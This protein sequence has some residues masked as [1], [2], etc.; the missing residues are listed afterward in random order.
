MAVPLVLLAGLSI[1]LGLYPS[2]LMNLLHAVIEFLG[3]EAL[4]NRANIHFY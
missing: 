1:Y 3:F 2:V 4:T